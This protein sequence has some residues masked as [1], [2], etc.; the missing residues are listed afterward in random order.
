MAQHRDYGSFSEKELLARD[1]KLK[2]AFTSVELHDAA[3]SLLQKNC[4][5]KDCDVIATSFGALSRHVKE[6]HYRFLCD[7]CLKNRKIFCHEHTMYSKSELQDHYRGVKEPQGSTFIGMTGHPECEFCRTR[8][9]DSDAL[10]EHCRDKHE[11]CHICARQNLQRWYY[12]YDELWKHFKKDHFVCEA[13]DCLEQKFV[14]FSTAFDLKVHQAEIHGAQMSGQRAQRLKARQIDLGFQVAGHSSSTNVTN[15]PNAVVAS[16]PQ[17]VTVGTATMPVR[18]DAHPTTHVPSQSV[19]PQTVAVTNPL[20]AQQRYRNVP[21]GFGQL[22]APTK[23]STISVSD[24]TS[25]VISNFDEFPQPVEPQTIHFCDVM[26]ARIRNHLGTDRS[27]M[28]RFRG[29][30]SAFFENKISPARYIDELTM[31]PWPGLNSRETKKQILGHVVNQTV[32]ELRDETRSSA[33]LRAWNDYRAKDS[34]Q[35]DDMRMSSI[36]LSSQMISHDGETRHGGKQAL[37]V[38]RGSSRGAWMNGHGHVWDRSAVES[39]ATTSFPPL[40]SQGANATAGGGYRPSWGDTARSSI[41]MASRAQTSLPAR[42]SPSPKTAIV[43]STTT[44]QPAAQPRPS[45]PSGAIEF[46]A[47]PSSSRSTL[48]SHIMRAPTTNAWHDSPSSSPIPTQ[49]PQPKVVDMAKK[50]GKKGKQV[51]FHVG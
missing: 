39:A 34:Q 15:Q 32:M 9:Y 17:S 44:I 35:V 13:P 6:A 42:P 43:R 3:K 7:I 28:L 16:R 26:Q 27:R 31:I 45:V 36:A 22:S 19:A 5:D 18:I 12:N 25:Q 21:S 14:V 2:L 29:L 50:K 51:L 40:S 49:E 38:K 46:P 37:G 33:L 47:L 48:R 41:S 20:P 11:S 10:Y 24:A 8:L 30:A 1:T 23:A 4:P